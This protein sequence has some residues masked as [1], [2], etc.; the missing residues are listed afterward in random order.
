V[1]SARLGLKL[2][3]IALAGILAVAPASRS[4]ADEL[5]EI[6]KKFGGGYLDAGLRISLGNTMSPV[7]SPTPTVARAATFRFSNT[8]S[9]DQ[10]NEPGEPNEGGKMKKTLWAR[11]R[12]PAKSRVVMHTFGSDFDTVL[13]V[14]TGSSVNHLTKVTSNDDRPVPGISGVHSLVQFDAKA[15]VDYSIQ[16]G[17]KTGAEGDVYL[18]AFVF[19][20]AG[21]ISAYLVS[22]AGNPFQ[23]RD[24]ACCGDPMFIAHNSTDG[25]ATVTPTHGLGGG[26]V[27]PAPFS[28][29]RGGLKTATFTFTSGFDRT[30]PRTRA[31]TFTF[32]ARKGPDIVSI[33]RVRALI[34]I[35]G[36]SRPKVLTAGGAACAL[37]WSE[38]AVGIPGNADQW[39]RAACHRLPFSQPRLLPAEDSV[40]AHRS[41]QRRKHRWV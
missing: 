30:T 36:A 8:G 3:A 5:D 14:Y 35:T 33:A 21:G 1:I 17:S 20:P 39:R 31:S 15:G 28:L 29:A 27:S 37:G 10:A 13:A 22:V 6:I 18:N 7:A 16:I 32:T 12:L 41:E 23:G 9:V 40:A 25:S 24:Y 34:A 2:F 4:F 38:R 19:P 11:L 26:I